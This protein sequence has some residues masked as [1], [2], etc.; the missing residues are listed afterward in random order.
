MKRYH[1]DQTVEPGTYLNLRQMIFKSMND[2]GRLPGT[3]ADVYRRVP[4]PALLVVGPLLGLAYVIF[5]PV[6]GVALL[7]WV[8]GSKAIDLAAR[9]AA[10]AIRILRPVWKPAMAFLSR[11]QAAKPASGSAPPPG[12]PAD[13]WAA[14]VRKQLEEETDEPA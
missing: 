13:V 10:P 7:A 9:A 8:I 1:G 4:A 12:K 6:I 5:L 2:K 3:K 14:D 11:G